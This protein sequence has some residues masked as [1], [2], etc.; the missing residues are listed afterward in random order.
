MIHILKYIKVSPRKG[1]IYGQNLH[2]K[3]VCYSLIRHDLLLIGDLHIDI[4][5]GEG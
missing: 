5:S 1:L 4:V 3:V 2:T